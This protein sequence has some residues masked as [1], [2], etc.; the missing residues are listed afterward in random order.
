MASHPL[1]SPSRYGFVGEGA[2]RP[3]TDYIL[4][5]QAQAEQ[6]GIKGYRFFDYWWLIGRFARSGT[7]SPSQVLP[8]MSISYMRD[9][10]QRPVEDRAYA[11]ALQDI[12]AHFH[13]PWLG[14]PYLD[15]LLATASRE[16]TFYHRDQDLVWEGKDKALF[17]DI[18]NALKRRISF[19]DID[20]ALRVFSIEIP[21][22]E[23]HVRNTKGFGLIHAFYFTEA[24][25][26][27]RNLIRSE[28]SIPVLSRNKHDLTEGGFVLDGF[29]VRK[30]PYK[31]SPSI[32][33]MPWVGT[34]PP[35]KWI[36]EPELLSR[37]LNAAL[38]F[39]WDE[40]YINEFKQDF[41]P[42]KYLTTVRLNIPA[43]L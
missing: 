21:V 20:Q 43:G 6:N 18:L 33:V 39:Q 28:L 42:V 25:E 15:Q 17:F 13:L 40:L 19:F 38:P 31:V 3:L 26:E 34:R 23:R 4:S 24:L 8:F 27:V 22:E 16:K 41:Q 11:R 7:Y 36:P 14:V 2:V 9:A 1:T 37:S 32:T 29:W 10:L 35:E 12:I 30:I 5:E